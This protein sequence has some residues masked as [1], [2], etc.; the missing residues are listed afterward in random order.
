MDNSTLWE[1]DTP[2]TDLSDIEVPAW[3][4]QNITPYDVAA[5]IQGGCESGAYMPAVTYH[6]ALTTMSEHG[7][8]VL[9][10]IDDQ[11]GLELFTP[12]ADLSW[13]GLACYYL[14]VA[15][16]L[17]ASGIEDELTEYLEN[18]EFKN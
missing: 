17:W 16:E 6:Q 8:D 7:D 10:F 13:S 1:N 18:L 2:V 12:P 15:V 14:S 9:D 3:I 11:G 4:D 5:I